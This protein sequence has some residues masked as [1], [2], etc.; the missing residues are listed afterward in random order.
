VESIDYS[1]LF[2][3]E[4]PY[5]AAFGCGILDAWK[6]YMTLW[7]HIKPKFSTPI[8][9]WVDTPWAVAAVLGVWE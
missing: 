5:K 3:N 7:T 4:V 8:F 1:L 6:T 2:S 9:S